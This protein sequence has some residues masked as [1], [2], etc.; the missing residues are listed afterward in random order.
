MGKVQSA[1]KQDI[2]PWVTPIVGD[3][4][5]LQWAPTQYKDDHRCCSWQSINEQEFREGPGAT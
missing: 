1:P 3:P 2:K 5:L 4:I